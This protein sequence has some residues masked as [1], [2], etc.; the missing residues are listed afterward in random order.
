MF[1]CAFLLIRY[2][3]KS[4][5]NSLSKGEKNSVPPPQLDAPIFKQHGENVAHSMIT[6]F[7][8]NRKVQHE[9]ESVSHQSCTPVGT[10]HYKDMGYA[11]T[12]P[13]QRKQ[14][15]RAWTLLPQAAA[16][17][18]KSSSRRSS[19]QKQQPDGS[20]PGLL[21]SGLLASSLV[22]LMQRTGLQTDLVW[23][24]ETEQ[25]WQGSKASLQMRS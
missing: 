13:C 1:I 23:E 15:L 11:S 18:E 4:R 21:C 12:S 10:G 16:Q 3:I 14:G 8:L 24:W 6:L 20:M 9:V 5:H 17:E 19:E 7:S 25:L 2:W 22:R